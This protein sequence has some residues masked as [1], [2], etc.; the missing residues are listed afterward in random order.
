MGKLVRIVIVDDHPFIIEGYKN[1]IN[2]YSPN[3]FEFNITQAN[4]CRSAYEL[5]TETET[6]FDI[7]FFDISMP[8][9]EEKGIHSGEDLARLIKEVMPDCKV[10]LLT[11]HTELLKI[12]TIIKNINPNG[13]IIKN[14][15]TFDEL[16]VAFDKILKSENYYSQ[17]V[18]KFVSQSQYDSIDLDPFDKQI[19]YHL[20]KGTK[21][22]DIPSFVPLSLSAVEKRKLNLKEMLEVKGGSDIELISEARNKG[23]L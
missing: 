10:V 11:M 2:S 7:A 8:S 3:E 1:A 21:T 12:N 6:P 17:T 4:N 14:D 19:L 5:I 15:L 16:L 20:S 9:Y 13:L 18:V 23:L 22:K